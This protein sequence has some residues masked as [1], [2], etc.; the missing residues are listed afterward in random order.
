MGSEL[1]S[2]AVRNLA[3]LSRSACSVAL[4]AVTSAAM[5]I[6]LTGCPVASRVRAVP[7]LAIHLTSPLGS[8]M[9]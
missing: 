5:W 8:T 6:V 1:V 9:R 7:L 3:S 4:R 2:K